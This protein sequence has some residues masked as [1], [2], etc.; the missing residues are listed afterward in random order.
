MKEAPPNSRDKQAAI[1]VAIDEYRDRD[2][3]RIEVRSV[4]G[5]NV[6]AAVSGS[7]SARA[8]SVEHVLAVVRGFLEMEPLR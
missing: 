8:T 3:V 1:E 5:T 6:Y 7:R 4:R 2:S